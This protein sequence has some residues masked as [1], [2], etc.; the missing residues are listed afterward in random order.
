MKKIYLM[1][2]M[3]SVL[4]GLFANGFTWYSQVDTRWKNNSLGSSGSSIGKSGCALSCV[5]MLLNG[6]A[7]NS[8]VTPDELNAWMRRNGGFA[9]GNLMRWQVPAEMDGSGSG[10][11]LQS[12]IN[13]ANDWKYLSE[14]L[15]KGNKV[16]VRVAGR[17]SHWVLVVK[18]DGPWDRASSYIVNDPGTSDYRQRTLAHFGGFVAARSYSG[19]WL[20][21]DAF[22]LATSINVA[23]VSEEEA[24]LYDLSGLPTPANI[25]VTLENRL[26]VDVT[27]YFILGLFDSNNRLIRSIDH[28]YA[29]VGASSSLDLIYEMQDIAPLQEAGADLKILY[30]KFFSEMPVLDEVLELPDSGS[31]NF[32]EGISIQ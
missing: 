31:L 14:E 1:I 4:C 11:E 29:I 16:V 13:R 6:E 28:E 30:S 18:R 7:S 27:G 15:D 12:V 32:T 20:D 5:S 10:V 3:T 23:P 24:F 9:N 21:E 22:D 8:R 19:I 2:I 17:R 26:T 25:Y